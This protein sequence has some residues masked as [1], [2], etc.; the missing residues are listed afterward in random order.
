MQTCMYLFISN[1]LC[2]QLTRECK[3]ETHAHSLTHTQ[4]VLNYLCAEERRV[5]QLCTKILTL[6]TKERR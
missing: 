2:T 4:E 5:F 6:T 3:C 1:T